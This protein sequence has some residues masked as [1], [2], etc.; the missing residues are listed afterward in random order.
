MPPE[1]TA[2]PDRYG[3]PDGPRSH[4]AYR[5]QTGLRR[6]RSAG[7]S[8]PPIRARSMVSR[9]NY[10]RTVLYINMIV[11]RKPS[12]LSM[13]HQPRSSLLDPGGRSAV[14]ISRSGQTVRD[15]SALASKP[16][17]DTAG[18]SDRTDRRVVPLLSVGPIVSH[19]LGRLSR[20]RSRRGVR[21][22]PAAVA[23]RPKTR[24]CDLR[25]PIRLA[26]RRPRRSVSRS[27]AADICR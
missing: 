8:P 9:D 2:V 26:N 18:R 15:G 24:P 16:V 13:R 10:K 27:N 25:R 6:G 20:I 1:V 11:T 21:H 17:R 23:A 12:D 22:V 7:R 3:S 5:D 14:V 19:R 4:E